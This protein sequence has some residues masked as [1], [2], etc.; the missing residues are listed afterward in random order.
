MTLSRSV[1]DRPCVSCRAA[2]VVPRLLMVGVLFGAMVLPLSAGE[3]VWLIT[4][5]EAAMAPPSP[6]QMIRSRALTNNGP[7]IEIVKPVENIPQVS[8]FEIQIRFYPKEAAVNLQSVKVHLVKFFSI[9]ITDR[10]QPYLSESGL[11]VKEA[12]IPAGTH[13]VRISVSDEKKLTSSREIE[14]EVK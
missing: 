8:P 10:V 12:K 7:R 14:L 13:L 4:P 2:G 9:D 6:E 11:E 1:A 3:H 5:D